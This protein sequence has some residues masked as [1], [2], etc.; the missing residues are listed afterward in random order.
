MRGSLLFCT[1]LWRSRVLLWRLSRRDVEARY[2]GTVL[3]LCWGVLQPL[4]MLVIY[5]FIFS[6]V[7]RARWGGAASPVSSAQHSP[8]LFALNLFAGLIVF[9]V[10]ADCLVRAPTL[11]VANPNYVRKVVFPLDVLAPVSM[12]GSLFTAG[13]SLLALAALEIVVLGGL[14]ITWLWLPMLWLPLV[15]GCCGVG[16][17]LSAL[18]V[19]IRDTAQVVALVVNILLYITPIFYPLQA[20]PPAWRPI[21]QLNPLAPLVEATRQA[22]VE[23]VAPNGLLLA[24]AVAVSLL[25]CQLSWRLFER[26]R[27]GFADV[28]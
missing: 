22:T 6:V 3:G 17:L 24:L 14:P 12:A 7:F 18:G 4:L 27:R 10:A 1:S 21:L 28:L 23:G 9:N 26:A 25:F 2:R 11:V 13:M 5:T 8:L 16:W 15:L 19:Y 20:L